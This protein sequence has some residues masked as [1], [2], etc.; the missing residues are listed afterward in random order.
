MG[1]SP[2]ARRSRSSVTCRSSSSRSEGATT[3]P[4]TS[5]ST[6]QATLNLLWTAR[7]VGGDPGPD[8]DVDELR[9]FGPDE[10]PPEDELAFRPNVANALS[11]WR[12]GQKHT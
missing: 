5:V 12:A 8:D 4:A 7:V 1:R 3:S 10:L 2:Q 6:A 9:W 11:A